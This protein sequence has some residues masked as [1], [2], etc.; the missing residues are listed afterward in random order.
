MAETA[1][2]ADRARMH[3]RQ[4]RFGESAEAGP[5]TAGPTPASP[6][7][8]WRMWLFLGT[9]C[10]LFGG[11]ISTYLLLPTRAVGGTP[12]PARPLRHPVHVGELVRAA[13]ELAHHG[14]GRHRHRPGRQSAT[15][16]CGCSPRPCSAAIFIGGQV[17]EFTSFVKEGMGFTTN[18]FGVGLLHAHRLPRRPR[19]SVGIIMLMSLFVM[20]LRGGLGPSGPR[21]S[22]SSASTGTSSTSCGS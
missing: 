5:S 9:E 16:G 17:Y 10:L 15:P 20:S 21:P 14:A 12:T 18:V 6:T 7:R 1:T 4:N 11:L 8:S 2:A 13:D 3:L 22:R 19:V